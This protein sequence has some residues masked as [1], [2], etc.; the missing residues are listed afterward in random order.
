MRFRAVYAAVLLQPDEDKARKIVSV[1]AL[2][3][4]ERELTT[5]NREEAVRCIS[6]GFRV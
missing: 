6:L 5:P 1:L 3:V 4:S 2:K